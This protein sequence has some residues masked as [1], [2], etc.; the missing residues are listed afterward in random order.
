MLSGPNS[1]LDEHTH[2][3]GSRRPD[4]LCGAVQLQKLF[5]CRETWGDSGWTGLLAGAKSR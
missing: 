3:Q 5:S 1:G 4:E 2:T